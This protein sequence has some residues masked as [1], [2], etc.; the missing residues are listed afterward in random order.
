VYNVAVRA[1]YRGLGI[2]RKLTRAA[3]EKAQVSGAEGVLIQVHE[4]NQTALELYTSLG[5]QKAEGETELRLQEIS[6]VPPAEAPGYQFRPWRPADAAAV[7]EMARLAIPAV[8]Q[9][10]RPIR[11]NRYQTSWWTPFVERLVGVLSGRRVYRLTMVKE[12][13]PA[14]M[15]AVTASSGQD[16]HRLELLI[17][18]DHAGQGEKALISRALHLLAAAPPRPAKITVDQSHAAILRALDRFGFEEQRTLL[19]LRKDFGS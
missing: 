14:A 7:R 5:F 17:H 3:I 16:A 18:P 8:Q 12:D 4:D 13:R 11:A 15:L 1:D 10:I 19:T 9:W 6:P 2:G